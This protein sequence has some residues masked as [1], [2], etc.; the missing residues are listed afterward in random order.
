M[1]R[2]GSRRAA[3]PRGNTLLEALISSA[4]FSVVILGVY[5]LYTGMQE[6]LNRGEVKTDL[7]QNAR[8]AAD[9][10]AQEL[11]LAGYA[12]L[13]P[14]GSAA[15][16]PADQALAAAGS[17]CLAFVNDGTT[18]TYHLTDDTSGSLPRKI[19]RRR[20]GAGGSQAYAEA[21]SLLAF[22]YYDRDQQVL[23]PEAVGPCPAPSGPSMALLSAAQLA[24]VV[25]VR[26]ALRTASNML[27]ELRAG[28]GPDRYPPEY[29]TVTT[30][31]RLRNR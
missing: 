17:D 21:V 5:L 9:R 10:L 2:A 30:D 14:S 15:P 8:V 27:S 1:R 12:S 11:R 18:I 28:V 22:T 3:R 29:Y 6:T 26:I 4:L 24:R 31:V 20:V 7:Q 25:R 13:P 19:V 23:S 16:Q